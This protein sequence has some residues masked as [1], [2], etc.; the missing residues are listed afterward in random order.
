MKTHLYYG[1]SFPE[2]GWVPAPRYLL[3]RQLVIEKMHN[4]KKGRVLEVGPGAGVLL[5]E[6]ALAG[7]RCC[8]L[9]PSAPAFAIAKEIHG[10]S[11]GAV[12]FDEP[13][14]GWK[15]LFDWLLALEVLEHIEDDA[16]ALAQWRKWLKPGGRLLLSVPARKKKWNSTDVWAGHYRRYEK[17]ELVALVVHA[18]FD[19]ESVENY[20]FPLAN[21]IQ[22]IR[23]W[24]H[25]R[26]LMKMQR[27]Y[28]KS[29]SKRIGSEQSG[30]LR[31]FEKRLYPLYNNF[32]G[33]CAMRLGLW[34]QRFFLNRDLGNGY[35]VEARRTD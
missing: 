1:P 25:A 26:Q 29:L 4:H 24:Y 3:R 32:V 10:G 23:S 9:E 27:D 21:M 16:G 15:E 12:I 22:P 35:L 19:I 28:A 5:Y 20:G 11:N 30:I 8:A 31:T 13:Q 14:T 18:G 2:K 17:S 33:V 6:L 34:L 7:W